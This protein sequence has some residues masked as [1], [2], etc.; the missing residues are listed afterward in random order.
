MKGDH[1]RRA[2]RLKGRE[3]YKTEDLAK[4]RAAKRDNYGKLPVPKVVN[5]SNE[6][7]GN[8]S[9]RVGVNLGTSKEMINYNIALI[10]SIEQTRLDLI[11]HANVQHNMTPNKK[12]Y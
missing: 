6:K 8:L 2:N 5:F 12:R 7:L 10:K 3:D 1:L 9:H 4:E 11:K